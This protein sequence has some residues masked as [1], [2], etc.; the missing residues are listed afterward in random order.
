MVKN[1]GTAPSPATMLS[2]RYLKRHEKG[3]LY[4][5]KSEFPTLNRGQ[6]D[7]TNVFITF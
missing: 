1:V 3:L 4:A 5:E 6:A 2:K 7:H